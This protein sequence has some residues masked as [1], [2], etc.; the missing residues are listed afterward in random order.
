[1]RHVL[2]IVLCLATAPAVA[3]AQQAD[4]P[5]ITVDAS[6][7]VQRAPDRAILQLAVEQDGP[8]AQAAAQASAT[9][10]DAV[11]RALRARAIP[12]ASIRTVSYRID[13]VYGRR[14]RPDSAPLIVGYRAMNLVEVTIDSIATVGAVIDAAIGAGANRVAGLS[15]DL[16]DREGARLAALELAMARAR[17]EAETVARAAGAG[18]GP[19]V[20]ISMASPDPPRPMLQGRMLVEAMAEPTPIE[21]GALAISAEVRVVYRLEVR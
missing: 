14:T 12:S 20:S 2:A 8:T 3:R 9:A 7:S 4:T 11:L 10:M 5:T 19:P 15:F 1:M 21:G 6:A 16:R 17:R 13:P 18:L